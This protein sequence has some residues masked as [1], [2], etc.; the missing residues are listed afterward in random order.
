MGISPSHKWLLVH[1]FS[2]YCLNDPRHYLD[3]S[4][5]SFGSMEELS[6]DKLQFLLSKEPK[7][8][9]YVLI[10]KFRKNLNCIGTYCFLKIETQGLTLSRHLSAE[11][12]SLLS[13]NILLR[14]K[15]SPCARDRQIVPRGAAVASCP[16]RYPACK[17]MW[18]HLASLFLLSIATPIYFLPI[19]TFPRLIFP[20]SKSRLLTG[21][22]FQVDGKY[23]NPSF[24]TLVAILPMLL[25]H[26]PYL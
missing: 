17:C 14:S 22:L 13:G 23:P 21:E 4:I 11:S 26:A 3:M 15:D 25:T 9:K 10:S 1:R 5:Y 24:Q 2:K 8:P 19:P 20:G 16:D 6:F 12:I 18:S 7:N